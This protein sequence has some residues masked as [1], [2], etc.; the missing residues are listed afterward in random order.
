MEWLPIESALRDGTNILLYADGY[1]VEGYWNRAEDKWDS[2]TS[3]EGAG[4][5]VGDIYA[6]PTHWQPLPNPPNA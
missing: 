3:Y 4:R 2:E 6:E 5:F 1:C